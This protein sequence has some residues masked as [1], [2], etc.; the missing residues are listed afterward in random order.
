ML[1]VSPLVWILLTEDTRRIRCVARMRYIAV[2][3]H[4]ILL[5]APCSADSPFWPSCGSDEAFA[6][7]AFFHSHT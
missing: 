5:C 7:D 4:H 6:G 3:L 1:V 2:L